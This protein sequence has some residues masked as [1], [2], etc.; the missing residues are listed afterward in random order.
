[1]N[2]KKTTYS[3]KHSNNVLGVV[4]LSDFIVAPAVDDGHCLQADTL[5]C[6]LGRQQE[7]MIEVVKKLVPTANQA[8]CQFNVIKSYT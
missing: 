6:N 8:I 3:F 7:S 1:M 4:K 5:H 2:L